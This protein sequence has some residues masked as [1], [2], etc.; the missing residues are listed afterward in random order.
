M[1]R[2]LRSHRYIHVTEILPYKYSAICKTE[3]PV[4][5]FLTA[6]WE[7]RLFSLAP[8]NHRQ[9]TSLGHLRDNSAICVT[10]HENDQV[11]TNVQ[12]IYMYLSVGFR[13]Q[14]MTLTFGMTC[15]M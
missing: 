15:R 2:I 6:R 4:L 8:A 14:M 12:F 7:I 3:L 11:V 1:A 9:G 13:T 10:F 5:D